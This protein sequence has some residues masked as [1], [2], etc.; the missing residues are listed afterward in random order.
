MQMRRL[1]LSLAFALLSAVM[2]FGQN[3]QLPTPHTSVTDIPQRA[4]Y[5]VAHYWDNADFATERLKII[6]WAA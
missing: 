2:S 1:G 5:V 3:F 6:S 4:S